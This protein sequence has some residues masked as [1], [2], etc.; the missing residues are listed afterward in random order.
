MT[1]G[2]RI[3]LACLA[4]PTVVEIGLGVIYLSAAAPM[5][6]HQEALGVP[7]EVLAPGVRTVLTGLVNAYGSAH[8]AVGIAMA[9]LVYQLLGKRQAWACWALLAVGAPVLVT[10]ALVSAHFARVTGAAVPWRGAAALVVVF[11]IGIA[12]AARGLRDRPG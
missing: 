4:L 6:Y 2:Q 9:V 7:W 8:L 1:T 10:T 12:L 5:P 11:L 3:A